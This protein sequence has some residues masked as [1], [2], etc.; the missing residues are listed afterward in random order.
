MS[1][2]PCP[3]AP[4]PAPGSEGPC[5]SSCLSS[6]VQGTVSE[7]QC[8]RS[9]VQGACVPGAVSGLPCPRACI[10][11]LESRGPCPSSRVQAPMSRAHIQGAVSEDPCLG[12]CVR[13]LKSRARVQG[14]KSGARG[15]K[16]GARIQGAVSELPCPEAKVQ[17]AMS[18]GPV[19][20]GAV[21]S[22]A[23]LRWSSTLLSSRQRCMIRF[24]KPLLRVLLRRVLAIPGPPPRYKLQNRPST[25]PRGLPREDQTRIHPHHGAR[26]HPG[27]LQR[28]W[29]SC[30]IYS[31][32]SYTLS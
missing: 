10:Q 17:G 16:S 22:V 6:G 14:L 7:C 5:L 29:T 19:S 12:A 26:T 23:Q 30:Q 4:F 3:E 28:A 20:E 13:G 24:P 27:V 8:P 1:E 2:H 9:C 21:G 31:E 11:G 15:L 25:C 18:R 32:A